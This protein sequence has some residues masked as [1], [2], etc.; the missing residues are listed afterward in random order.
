MLGRSRIDRGV[1]GPAPRA[2]GRWD[3]PARAGELWATGDPLV[4]RRTSAASSC[5]GGEAARCSLARG[6]AGAGRPGAYLSLG[7]GAMPSASAPA[8]PPK[9][10]SALAGATA[11]PDATRR[12][13]DSPDSARGWA[14]APS[15]SGSAASTRCSTWSAAGAAGS[16]SPSAPVED[17]EFLHASLVRTV[18]VATR[19][20][21]PALA[22]TGGRFV[23]VSSPQAEPAVADERR[24]R[25]R[26]GRRRGL[27]AG[28]GP[29]ARAS[30]AARPTW[31]A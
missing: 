29:G 31:S 22:E 18:Q 30:T 7:R 19:A 6:G 2:F 11:L 20:F 26:E 9:A 23:I 12:R 3:D 28:A 4:R 21:L 16:R 13:P 17:D 15:A 14:D 27:D 25:R 24:L 10:R 1:S 5:A 8:D